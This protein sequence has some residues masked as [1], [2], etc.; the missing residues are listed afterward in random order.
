MYN[1]EGFDVNDNEYMEVD[2]YS[3]NGSGSYNDYN[4]GGNRIH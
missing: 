4:R 1:D 2:D 3:G